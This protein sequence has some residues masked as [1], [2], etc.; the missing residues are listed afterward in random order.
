VIRSVRSVEAG[1]RSPNIAQQLNSSMYRRIDRATIYVLPPIALLLTICGCFH[2]EDRLSPP[3]YSKSAISKAAFELLDENS[4]GRLE[5]SEIELAPGLQ[6]AMDTIDQNGDGSIDAEELAARISEYKQ[7]GVGLRNE[8]YMFTVNGNALANA[9]ITFEP[10]PFF[11]GI[12]QPAQGKTKSNGSTSLRI[13]GKPLPG[14]AC[15]MYRVSVS[16]KSS[17]GKEMLPKKFNSETTLGYEFPPE[18]F[19]SDDQRTFVLKTR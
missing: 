12:L 16:K 5:L 8:V 4:D 3:R 7:A 11:E 15:G 6:V 1:I 9:D 13:E 18:E 2:N 19:S 17:N 14:L 10:E